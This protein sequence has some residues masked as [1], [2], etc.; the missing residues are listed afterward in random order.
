[1]K[2]YESCNRQCIQPFKGSEKIAFLF[3]S[4]ALKKQQQQ[5]FKPKTFFSSKNVLSEKCVMYMSVFA[6]IYGRFAVREIIY[7]AVCLS[8]FLNTEKNV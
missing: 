7:N 1:M 4:K 8:S 6:M 3:Y 5:H 2:W